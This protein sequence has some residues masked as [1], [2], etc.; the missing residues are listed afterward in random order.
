MR[1]K[2][3]LFVCPFNSARSQMAE[4]LLNA[5]CG[6]RYDAYSA[7]I[8]T[9]GLNPYAVAVMREI[10]IDIAYQKSKNLSFFGEA[11]FDYLIT[12]C[13]N[14]RTALGG[15]VPVGAIR[16][17]HGFESPSEAHIDKEVVLAEFRTLRDDIDAWLTEIFPDCPARPECGGGRG[18]E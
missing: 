11:R 7:G 10:G 2:T 9:A 1:K 8:T 18:E 17:H 13:D 12:L 14:A 4:G 5:R 15:R 6:S 16:I 3:V